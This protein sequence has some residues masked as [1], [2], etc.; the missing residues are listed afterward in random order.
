MSHL[1][2]NGR[3]IPFIN[4]SKYLCV[5]FD[6]RIT[7]RLQIEMIE[8]KTFRTFVRVY[9]LFRIERL[10]SNI[11]LTLHKALLISVMTYVSPPWEF[12]ADTHLMKLQ[13]VQSKVSRTI[14]NIPRHALVR[15]LHVAF[16]IPYAYDYTT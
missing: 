16:K 1:I 13:R 7:W 2:L 9:S 8:T 14:G 5:I 3:N 11:K 4:S 10:G 15:D 12:G 6:K